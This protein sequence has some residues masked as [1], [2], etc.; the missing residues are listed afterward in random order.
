M[1]VK[2]PVVELNAWKNSEQEERLEKRELMKSTKK[3]HLSLPKEHVS[4]TEKLQLRIASVS[5][6]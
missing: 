2:S 1:S 3:E 6:R 4:M 5:Q